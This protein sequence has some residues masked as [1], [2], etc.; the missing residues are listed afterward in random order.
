MP[1]I[2]NFKNAR[3]YVAFVGL[4]PRQYSSGSS[5][6]GKQRIS[7][8]G[9]PRM[10]KALFMPALVI[11][12][13]N[14]YFKDFCDRLMTKGKCSKVIIVAVMRKLMH[15]VFGMLKNNALFDHTLAFRGEA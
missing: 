5:V 10:R 13:K 12:N 11:K 8:I 2:K 15:I 6:R 4:N 9:S 1:P 7:K 14:Q 3:E